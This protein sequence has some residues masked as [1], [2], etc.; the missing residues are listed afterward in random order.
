MALTSNEQIPQ[1]RSPAQRDQLQI[2]LSNLGRARQGQAREVETGKLAWA[3]SL[4]SLVN[5]CPYYEGWSLG[6]LTLPHRPIFLA[7]WIETMLYLTPALAPIC[8]R[9]YHPKPWCKRLLS[10]WASSVNRLFNTCRSLFQEFLHLAS[11]ALLS[12]S[13]INLII[14]NASFST[15][16]KPMYPSIQTPPF[17]ARNLN[18]AFS[19][20]KARMIAWAVVGWREDG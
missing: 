17:T 1:S 3:V 7:E 5:P 11:T 8:Q 14:V 16:T 15:I 4:S 20:T 18:R 2:P 13:S 19:T 6:L 12:K 9:A 10:I